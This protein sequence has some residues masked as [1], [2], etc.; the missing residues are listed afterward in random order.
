MKKR[1]RKA[2]TTHVPL[3]F[4]QLLLLELILT[5]LGLAQFVL[6]LVIQLLQLDVVG[7]LDF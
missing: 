3:Q 2:A 5:G 1:K 7:S 4:F 6:D